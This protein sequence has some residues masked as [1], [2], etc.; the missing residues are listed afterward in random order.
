MKASGSRQAITNIHETIHGSH[1]QLLF[2]QGESSRSRQQQLHTHKKQSQIGGKGRQ[3]TIPW[4]SIPTS[5]DCCRVE[6]AKAIMA[7]TV[8][9]KRSMG[10]AHGHRRLDFFLT[11]VV[12]CWRE[13][14]DSPWKN[15][16]C[17]CDPWM[18]SWIWVIAW[19]DIDPEA[20][21]MI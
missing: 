5:N 15:K 18:V 17:R 21:M 12:C 4:C 19:R 11:C 10:M 1:Q 6:E 16:S 13:R 3:T 7:I 20:F 14:E 2:F 8:V 9:R